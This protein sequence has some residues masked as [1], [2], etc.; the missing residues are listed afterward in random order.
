MAIS[1][2]FGFVAHRTDFNTAYLVIVGT[3]AAMLVVAA[4]VARQRTTR[5]EPAA[6]VAGETSVVPSGPAIT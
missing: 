3:A 6:G 1:P 4:A 2:S 5:V